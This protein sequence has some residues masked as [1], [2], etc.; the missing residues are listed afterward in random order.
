[1][2]SEK[3]I[4]SGLPAYG[5]GNGDSELSWLTGKASAAFCELRMATEQQIV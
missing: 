1:M 5:R 4:T 3:L 2:G